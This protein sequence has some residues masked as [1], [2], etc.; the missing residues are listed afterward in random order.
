MA[1]EANGMKVVIKVIPYKEQIMGFSNPGR[2][3]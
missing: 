2:M 3:A 1:T